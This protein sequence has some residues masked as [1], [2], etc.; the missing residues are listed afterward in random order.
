MGQLR[1]ACWCAQREFLLPNFC[2]RER[3]VGVHRES[4]CREIFVCACERQRV[5]SCLIFV[6]ARER[7]MGREFSSRDQAQSGPIP[8]GGR[9]ELIFVR[10]VDRTHVRESVCVFY[11]VVMRINE[12]LAR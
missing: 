11:S 6:L 3:P 1:E 5:R 9:S 12:L 7:R 10:V 8:I 4:S 2:V